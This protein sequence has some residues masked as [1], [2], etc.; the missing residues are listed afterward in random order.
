MAAS[1]AV[2]TESISTVFP[3]IGGN[4]ISALVCISALGAVNGLIFTGARIS[5][6]M[7]AEHRLFRSLGRWHERTG[8]PAWALLVQGVIALTFIVAFGSF[9]D[10]VLYTAAAVY[11]FY[12][13]TNLA[14]IVLRLREPQTERPFKIVGYPV[15]TIIFCAACA[16]LIYSSVTYALA[17][18]RLSLTVLACTLAAGIVIYLLTDARKSPQNHT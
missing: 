7:G 9:I 15:T 1:K 16:F 12:L 8:T 5:Y 13:A 11:S 3:K 18:K 17:F 2:A 10:T 6:A 14:V 4:L